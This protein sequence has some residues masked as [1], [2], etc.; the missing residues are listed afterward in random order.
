M[1]GVEFVLA[2]GSLFAKTIMAKRLRFHPKPQPS[3]IGH[4]Q[5]EGACSSRVAKLLVDN[6]FSFGP[7][8][9]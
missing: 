9:Y 7:L 2:R 6:H 1:E 4:C 5:Q 3:R 8:A